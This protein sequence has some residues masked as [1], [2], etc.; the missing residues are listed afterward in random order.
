MAFKFS[1][2]ITSNQTEIKH[3][4]YIVCTDSLSSLDYRSHQQHQSRNVAIEIENSVTQLEKKG[5]SALFKW[6]PPHCSITGNELA[7]QD[8]KQAC[9]LGLITQIPITGP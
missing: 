5:L 6:L 3:Q 1:L 2:Q 4:K 7:D 8:A 9:Q